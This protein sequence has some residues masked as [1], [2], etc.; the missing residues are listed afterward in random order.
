M[1][2][3]SRLTPAESRPLWID[4]VDW[5]EQMSKPSRPTVDT[6]DLQLEEEKPQTAFAVNLKRRTALEG[7][8]LQSLIDAVNN[9]GKVTL[10]MNRLKLLRSKGFETP[11][12]CNKPEEL[13]E[14]AAVLNCTIADLFGIPA[15]ESIHKPDAPPDEPVIGKVREALTGPKKEFLLDAIDLA[16]RD[17][18]ATASSYRR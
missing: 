4:N 7:Y 16:Y 8:G 3:S 2:S 1:R 14:I 6:L 12:S 15:N 18:L 17:F 10:T 9:R 13:A 5:Y 11:E